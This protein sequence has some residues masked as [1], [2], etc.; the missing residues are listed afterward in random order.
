M[1]FGSGS[2]LDAIASRYPGGVPR[3]ADEPYT[4]AGDDRYRRRIWLSPN[5]LSP[6]GTAEAYI[7]WALTADAA[8]RDASAVTIEGTNV[9]VNAKSKIA[10]EAKAQASLKGLQVAVEGQAAVDVKSPKTSVKGDGMLELK[11]GLVQIN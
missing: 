4:I 5:V 8:L 6:H 1:A 11:G 3:L 2:D 9:T 7:F 10:M